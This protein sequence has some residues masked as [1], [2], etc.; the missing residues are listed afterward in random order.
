MP[1][2]PTTNDVK[3]AAKD[4]AVAGGGVAIGE[5]VGRSVLGPGV[6]TAAGGILAASTM[7]GNS[8]EMASILAVERGATE[9]LGGMGGGDSGGGGNRSRM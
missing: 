3:G 6:G 1:D 8:R 9:L 4:G 7:S 5:A 2:V